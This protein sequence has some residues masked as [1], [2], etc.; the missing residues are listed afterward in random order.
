MM[1]RQVEE[2]PELPATTRSRK[3][4]K[5]NYPLGLPEGA[6]PDGILISDFQLMERGQKPF[7]ASLAT[8]P[9]GVFYASSRKL[10]QVPTYMFSPSPILLALHIQE[11]VIT[12]FPLNTRIQVSPLP[13][14]L[15]CD[16]GQSESL[17]LFSVG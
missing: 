17:L 2:C 4:G 12:H 16:F 8:L 15:L 10:I 13:F 1:S 3:P 5:A 6:N 7:V 9:W 14:W 11:I